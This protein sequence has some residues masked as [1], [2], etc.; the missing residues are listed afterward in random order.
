MGRIA[1]V[2]SLLMAVALA[3]TLVNF[4]KIGATGSTQSSGSENR[5]NS[6]RLEKALVLY[7]GSP[8]AYADNAETFIDPE[9]PEVKPVIKSGNTLVPVRFISEKLGARVDWD[10]S[11]ETALISLND[12]Q[13][14]LKTGSS[15]MLLGT[16]EVNLE[17]SAEVQNGR[18]LVPLRAL[19][20]AFGKK[21]FYDKGLIVI[22]DTEK[23]LNPESDKNEIDTLI[24]KVNNLPAVGTYGKLKELVTRN[25]SEVDFGGI[26]MDQAEAMLFNSSPG[27]DQNPGASNKKAASIEGASQSTRS[28]LTEKSKENYSKTNV[29]VEG[30]DEG[31][32]IKTDG[33][34]IYQVN[35]QRVVITKAYPAEDMKILS[36]LNFTGMKFNPQELYLHG[37]K[38]LVIGSTYNEIA[39]PEMP[40]KKLEKPYHPGYHSRNTVKAIIYD[41]ND[42][43]NIKVV[44]EVDIEGRYVS[45]RK[46]GSALY[47][48]A[49]KYIDHYLL[50]SELDGVT[51]CYRD[52][53]VKD[54][55]VYIQYPEIRYFP[56]TIAS[57]Y[58]TIAG[59]NI[60]K[61][62]EAAT[63]STY[64]GAGDKIY[65][66]E[67]NLYVAT[68]RHKVF[69]NEIQSQS[70]SSIQPGVGTNVKIR[71]RPSYESNTLIY[72]FSLNNGRATYLCQGEIPG[73]V[74]NQFSMDEYGK[75]F[76]IATTKQNTQVENIYTSTNNVY[77][78]DEMLNITGKIENMAPGERIYSVRFMGERGYV[79]TFKNVDPLF[80][81]DLKDPYKP[82]ILGALKIPGYSDYLHPYDD[83]HIIGFGK[84]TIEVG[85]KDRNG[86]VVDTQAFYQG[87]KIAIFDVSDVSN[88][89]QKFSEIIGDRGTDS[90]LLHNH[91]ALLFSREKNLLAFPVTVA[92][93]KNKDTN[94]QGGKGVVQYG[95]FAFQGAYVYDIDLVNGF[96]L[97]GRIT[98]LS[99]EE[100]LKAGNRWYGGDKTVQRIIYIGDNLYTMSQG[101]IKANKMSDLG[102]LNK[103]LIP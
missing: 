89:I 43:S 5:D 32:I 47:L 96:K 61:N 23:I 71:R 88:P 1:R 6:K 34:Y 103:L 56:G 60:D 16:K 46:I 74:L 11:T 40:E 42:K 80:V 92:E 76:R 39:V 17:V 37:D 63:F 4:D 65:A 15:K 78:T 81:I 67:Q 38:M 69:E 33:E 100:Y 31:D 86:N 14:Q 55:Y 12:K 101:M 26:K 49:N 21:V 44:R 85:M 29:Q 18:M 9:N 64:L 10:G 95:S 68:S 87:M 36:V 59:L 52:T 79:V 3:V 48:V 75:Y 73:N 58:M 25:N 45:S 98:H 2:A 27:M 90:E 28:G 24:T 82:S 99:N 84:D 93:V 20:E 30:V 70:D 22:S 54:D 19:A 91:R 57:N 94:V 72:K 83:K 77:I 51:P 62:E 41:I 53:T 13:V 102:E 7:I 50:Q 35:K 8:L 97:K 66:S